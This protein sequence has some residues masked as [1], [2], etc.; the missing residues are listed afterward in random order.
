MKRRH[1]EWLCQSVRFNYFCC[2]L[3]YLFIGF[4][5]VACTALVSIV[6]VTESNRLSNLVDVA[7]VAHCMW[8]INCENLAKPLSRFLP[9]TLLFP[10][11]VITLYLLCNQMLTI[12]LVLLFLCFARLVRLLFWFWKLY[13]FPANYSCSDRRRRYMYFYDSVWFR[14]DCF[15]LL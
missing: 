12:L 5:V 14:F 15:V 10:V 2:R 9:F 6:I 8:H 3:C 11:F 4:A 13:F 7:V 1:F